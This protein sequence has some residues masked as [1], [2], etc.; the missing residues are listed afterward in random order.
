VDVLSIHHRFKLRYNPKNFTDRVTTDQ[1]DIA[2]ISG[3]LD[4]SE[5]LGIA[6]IGDGIETAEQLAIFQSEG[7]SIIQGFYFSQPVT[8]REIPALIEKGMGHLLIETGAY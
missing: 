5:N 7:C 1:K 4:I 8:G 3:F 6:V 2:I